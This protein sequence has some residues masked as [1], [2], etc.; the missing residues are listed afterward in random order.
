MRVVPTVGEG[1]PRPSRLGGCAWRDD[2]RATVKP[3]RGRK[4]HDDQGGALA[5]RV[6]EFQM[7]LIPVSAL[8]L[9][10]G[11]RLA[12][13]AGAGGRRRRMPLWIATPLSIALPGAARRA[14]VNVPSR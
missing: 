1:P 8:S 5:A 4:R 13:R 11:H 14:A 3:D 7:V 12:H 6:A 9:L 10:A 2:G